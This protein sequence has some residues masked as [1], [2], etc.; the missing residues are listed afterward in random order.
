MAKTTMQVH[1]KLLTLDVSRVIHLFGPRFQAMGEGWNNVVTTPL[2]YYVDFADFQPRTE[3]CARQLFRV[4][5]CKKQ[6]S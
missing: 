3:S 1:H 4:Q 6:H 5:L 2:L